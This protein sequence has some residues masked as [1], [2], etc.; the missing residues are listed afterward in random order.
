MPSWLT[1]VLCC[2]SSAALA[3]PDAMEKEML[4]GLHRDL[5]RSFVLHQELPL[6]PALRAAAD[7]MSAAHLARTD[8][9][10]QAWV[11]QE[12]KLQSAPGEVHEAWELYFAVW[13]K[14]LNELALWQIEA[15][16]AD[17]ENATLAAVKTSPL[18]C[19]FGGDARFS[20]FAS[21]IARLQAM[22]AARRDAALA[23][24]RQ[25]LARWG[26][27]RPA[28]APWPA[29]LS[30]DAAVAALIQAGG[31]QT[32]LA[33]PPVLAAELLG[34][35]K[36]YSALHP[37]EQCR[38]QQWW[39]RES[40][41]RG[42]PP[43]AAL[44]AFRYGTLITAGPRFAGTFDLPPADGKPEPVTDKPPYP[45]IALR[46]M[47]TGKTTLSVRF[48]AA[49]K[50][51]DIVVIE[52]KVDM[53]GVRDAPPVAFETIFDQAAIKYALDGY[54][55]DK[56]TGDLPFKFQLVWTLPGVNE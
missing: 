53:P 12:R 48:D 47:V 40:L 6:D 43:A 17:Y 11:E 2:A 49:G 9:L 50:P 39:L 8:Q 45:K 27:V 24:E 15:G 1:L 22:P 56:P 3:A 41:R 14:V 54:R 37:E 25:L 7:E 20:D 30:H 46:F 34:D 26:Q 31:Q 32:R 55:Y 52:R 51:K 18:I 21:R 28:P 10:L 5:A 33:L 4:Q 35:R 23:T 44:N 36:D 42:T 29:Q 19:R 13:A 38:L 16:D